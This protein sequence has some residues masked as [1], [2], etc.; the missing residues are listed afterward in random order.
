MSTLIS[1]APADRPVG[2]TSLASAWGIALVGSLVVNLVVYA[3]VRAVVNVPTKFQPLASPTFVV[4]YTVLG[5]LGAALVL[6]LT[7]RLARRSASTF[8]LG[9]ALAVLVLTLLTIVTTTP[10]AVLLIVG[11]IGA[12][13]TYA[14][15]GSYAE[16]PLAA[17]QVVAVVM[18]LISFV[19]P[20]DLVA[21]PFASQ[22]RDAWEAP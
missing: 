17:F 2:F 14:V 18:L 21:G 12:A 7:L 10:I 16:R 8:R 20:L 5:T 4:A 22:Y 6:G 13:V 9:L 19:L 3:V 11:L 15:V 1:D